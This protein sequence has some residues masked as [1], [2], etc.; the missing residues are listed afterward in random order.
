MKELKKYQSIP[1]F[2]VYEVTIEISQIEG[3]Y[4][5]YKDIKETFEV[6]CKYEETAKQRARAYLNCIYPELETHSFVIGYTIKEI[7]SEVIR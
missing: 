5:S 2:K 6:C 1:S 3:Y 4:G 7:I